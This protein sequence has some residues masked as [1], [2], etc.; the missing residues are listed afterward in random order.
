MPSGDACKTLTVIFIL[1]YVFYYMTC[2]NREVQEM[3]K[4]LKVLKELKEL[5]VKLNGG[6]E[7]TDLDEKDSPGNDH[8]ADF[9]KGVFRGHTH[10][11]DIRNNYLREG[12]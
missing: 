6:Y 12:E 3:A 4:E 5:K 9:K 7:G 11:W 8:D 2:I 1:S 10:R